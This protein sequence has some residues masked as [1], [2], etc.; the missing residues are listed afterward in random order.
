M[1]KKA[2]YHWEVSNLPE[3]LSGQEGKRQLEALLSGN[4]EGSGIAAGTAVY[5]QAEALGTRELKTAFLRAIA[6]KMLIKAKLDEYRK[7]LAMAYEQGRLKMGQYEEMLGFA[8]ARQAQMTHDKALQDKADVEAIIQGADRD[9]VYGLL[10]GLFGE[11]Q[12]EK[13][14]SGSVSAAIDIILMDLF[15]DQVMKRPVNRKAGTLEIQP[16]RSMLGAA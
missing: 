8:L 7:E 4:L 9:N 2:A 11:I 12:G 16:V 10:N 6:E 14:R 13:P 3:R 15:I 5:E 1:A